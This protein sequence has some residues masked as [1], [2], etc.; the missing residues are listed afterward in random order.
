[1]DAEQLAGWRFGRFEIQ[2]AQR[3]LLVDGE[4]AA[5]GARAFDLL[6]ALVQRRDRLVPK[7]E[8]LDLVW[9]GLVVEENNLQVQISTLRKL[10]GPQSIAT[11][12]GRGYRFT[13]TDVADGPPV[14]EAGQ[15]AQS[16]PNNLP[17]P[18]T[19]FIGREAALADCARLLREA[20]LLTLTGIG[21][22]GKTR[23][24]LQLARQLLAAF[25][26]GV[27]FVDLAPVQDQQRV[28]AAVA[29]T[30]NVREE[31]GTP[32]AAR[33]IAHLATRHMVIV[34]DNC[35]HVIGPVVEL[36]EALLAACG[37]L[38]I[39]ATSREALGVNGEQIYPVRS[40]TLPAAADPD[41]MQGS[42]A[43]RVFVDRARLTLPDFALD[44]CNAPAIAEICR[45]LDG[46]ALAIELA[47]A[48]VKLLSVDEIRL[49]INDRFRLLTGGSRSLARHQTLQ[50]TLQWSYEHLAP[51][52]QELL[53]WL[54]V[55][56][57]GW[58]LAAATQVA[59]ADEYDVLERLTALHDKSL[60]EVDR[61]G[62]SSPRYRML[63][64]VR[65]FAQERLDDAG[66]GD[67]TR[68]RHLLYCVALAEEAA[69]HLQGREQGEWIAW[70]RLEQENLLAA[71]AWCTHA[72]GGAELGLRLA[73]P[74]WRYWLASA[75][76]ERG[77]R[78]AKAA[79]EQAGEGIDSKA[80]CLTIWA[81]G[82]LAL[83]MGRYDETLTFARQSLA[84]AR[85]I[86]DTELTA[87]GHGLLAVGFHAIGERADALEETNVPVGSRTN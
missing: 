31:A 35:E 72:P 70:L 2:P 13:A 12:P 39:I 73:G 79:L 34:L 85:R 11:V 53:R 24:A 20:R 44:E 21:G 47:A 69:L 75:Q 38:K 46:I 1:M 45:R 37:Q 86:E 25:P 67:A 3:L 6:L 81:I 8:L 80:R 4:S 61:D 7:E 48:R 28:A 30:L 23:L 29:A 52:E 17:Q 60:L 41:A 32:L 33:L 50:A 62:N 14:A 40:L 78:L 15:A 51:P 68:T 71:H 64:T 66:D 18:R 16:N 84:M 36:S 59:A 63:E 57:G 82:Q 19:R 27:W 42:E 83:Y 54:S 77:Y 49:R 55:F 58:T 9:P 5:L 76:L 26:D 43:V 22:C 65:Q 87:M 10:L 56:A 74:L